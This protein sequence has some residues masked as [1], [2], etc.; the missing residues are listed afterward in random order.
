MNTHSVM[1]DYACALYCK[2]ILTVCIAHAHLVPRLGTLLNVLTGPRHKCI[3]L[4]SF[5]LGDRLHCNQSWYQ[6]TLK[7]AVF[8]GLKTAEC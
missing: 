1:Q 6:S 3:V 4:Q 7:A 8:H 2:C 5:F